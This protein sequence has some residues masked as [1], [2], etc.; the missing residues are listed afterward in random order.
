MV[1][2]LS[3]GG[4]IDC[5]NGCCTQPASVGQTLRLLVVPGPVIMLLIGLVFI[6]KHPIDENRRQEIKVQLE[7]LR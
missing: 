4:Y 1:R 7:Q 3:V 2:I 5:P 6:W